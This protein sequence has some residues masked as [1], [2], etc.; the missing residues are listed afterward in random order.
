MQSR[1][2][3]LSLAKFCIY[4]WYHFYVL[5]ININTKTY[6]TYLTHKCLQLI[7]VK[8]DSPWTSQEPP[9]IQYEEVVFAYCENIW[10]IEKK[11]AE[12]VQNL[13]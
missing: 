5:F 10:N 1:T 13:C 2:Q 11:C 3:I 7:Y 6:Q 9:C 12:K 8:Y 4:P